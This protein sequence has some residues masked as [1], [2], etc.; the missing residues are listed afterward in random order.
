MLWVVG[1]AFLSVTP[2]DAL[3][4]LDA[5]P[6]YEPLYEP[7]T[8]GP[9]NV[10]R[11]GETYLL[12]GK[13]ERAEPL[14]RFVAQSC[15]PLD[16]SIDVAWARVR[17]GELLEERGDVQS[18]CAQ[19]EAILARWRQPRPRSVAAERATERRTRLRCR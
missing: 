15:E 13:P 3:E 1:Y 18:A 12:A 2:E 5:L 19:Y 14:L 7:T 16:Y 17:L 10:L 8:L 6:R 4:A 11:V 9:N